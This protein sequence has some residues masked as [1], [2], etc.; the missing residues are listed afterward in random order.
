MHPCSPGSLLFAVALT[1]L[2]LR[3]KSGF[4]YAEEKSDLLQVSRQ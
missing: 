4:S 2:T 1:G 3:I